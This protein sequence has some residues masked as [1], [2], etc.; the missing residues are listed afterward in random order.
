MWWYETLVD[1]FLLVRCETWEK[2]TTVFYK[3]PGVFVLQQ[4]YEKIVEGIMTP[5]CTHLY[6]LY[7][8]YIQNVYNQ[9]FR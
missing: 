6:I 8:K 5:V 3:C 2:T 9:T 1:A 7:S 4:K